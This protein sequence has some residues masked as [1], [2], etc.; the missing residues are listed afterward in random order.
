MFMILLFRLL[1][2]RLLE[3]HLDRKKLQRIL[4]IANKMEFTVCVCESGLLK[5][6]PKFCF[7]FFV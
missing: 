1:L 4:N 5:T 3:C 6:V 7:D 2:K